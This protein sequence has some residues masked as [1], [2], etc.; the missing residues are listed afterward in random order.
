MAVTLPTRV[1]KEILGASWKLKAL[2]RELAPND[3]EALAATGAITRAVLP[4]F[5]ELAEWSR[6]L[7]LPEMTREL[8]N[9]LRADADS[10]VA[11]VTETEH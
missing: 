8:Y 10:L 6:S 4:S 7:G 1:Q 11:P 2:I 3:W 5:A 9:S